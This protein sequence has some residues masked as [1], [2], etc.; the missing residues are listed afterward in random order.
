MN[1]QLCRK[2]LG[3]NLAFVLVFKLDDWLDANFH[4]MVSVA[5][6]LIIY[7]CLYLP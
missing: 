1:W 6:M 5:I 2:S 3:C 7:G 4:N